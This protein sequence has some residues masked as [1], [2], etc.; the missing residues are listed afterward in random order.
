M[1]SVTILM[2]KAEGLFPFCDGET[3]KVRK[4]QKRDAIIVNAGFELHVVDST[5]QEWA[6]LGDVEIKLRRVVA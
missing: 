6:T 3:Y 2:T 1:K 5:G 4:R